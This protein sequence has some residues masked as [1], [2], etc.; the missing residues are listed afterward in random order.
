MC[1]LGLSWRN[2]FGV[3]GKS[4]GFAEISNWFKQLLL[5]VQAGFNNM[6]ENKRMCTKSY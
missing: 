6:C 3:C 2:S 5:K 4:L 1:R